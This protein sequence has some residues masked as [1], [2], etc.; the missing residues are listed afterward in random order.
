[1]WLKNN[2]CHL[3]VATELYILFLSH[4]ALFTKN[5]K[6]SFIWGRLSSWL[7]CFI[8]AMSC[9]LMM[10]PFLYSYLLFYHKQILEYEWLE[11]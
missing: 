1:M 9:W 7:F 8:T 3:I 2:S 11:D 5:L 4:P 6:G 10:I